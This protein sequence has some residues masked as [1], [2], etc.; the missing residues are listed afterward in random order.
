[1]HLRNGQ[2]ADAHD[3]L[4]CRRARRA[5]GRLGG[6]SRRGEARR[7]D[8]PGR[9]LDPA[10][11]AGRRA[12]PRCL[13]RVETGGSVASH[14][15]MNLPG[16][17]GAAVGCRRVRP[18]LG[19]LRD[20]AR[21]RPARRLVRAPRERPRPGQRKAC[22]TRR[23]HADDREDREAR[24]GRARRGDRPGVPTAASWSRAATSASRCRSR[25]CPRSRSACCAL[26]GRY[27]KPCIT[28]TQMLASMVRSTRPTRAEA[29]DVANAVYDGTDALMLSE[30]TAI[31]QHPIEAVRMMSRIAEVTEHDLPYDEWLARRTRHAEHDVADT[32]SYSAVVA[33]YQLDLAALVV[34]D[35]QRA[36]GAAGVGSPPADARCWRLS[37]RPATVRRLHLLFGVTS[38][39]YHEPENARRAARGL[40]RARARPGPRQV[41]R[42]DRHHGRTRRTGA[43]DE[44]ARGAPG[45]LKSAF[46]TD[47]TCG[48]GPMC[49]ATAP[50]RVDRTWYFDRLR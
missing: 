32:L 25:R 1:M 4:E 30:E 43:R 24:G 26:A 45:S 9:R 27:S 7:R 13:T 16:R 28:A 36:H 2:V 42:P 46:S 10:E 48:Q 14:Q 37:E 34:P 40:R 33:A 19:R 50:P 6:P 29:T 11:R 15:G 12:T 49:P 17:G 21:D 41:G 23:R 18:R 20:R 22:R 38:A 5:A 3:Q 31:G 39:H 8:L 44:P 47:R 35:A